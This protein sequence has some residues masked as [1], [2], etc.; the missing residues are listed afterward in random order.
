MLDRINTARMAHGLAPL[1]PNAQLTA[2]ANRHVQ[3]IARNPWITAGDSHIG[4]DG[5]SAGERIRQAG[6]TGE[7]GRECTG[8]GWGDFGDGAQVAWWLDSP[9][10][11]AILLNPTLNEAGVAFQTAIAPAQW[12]RYWVVDFGRGG[13][14]MPSEPPKPPTLPYQSHIPVVVAGGAKTVDLLSY[15]RGDGRAYRVGNSRGSFEVFQTQTEGD[16]FYQIKAWDDLSVVNWEGFSVDD[17]Y[18][19]RD[20]D[21]SPGDG[22]FYRQFD[23]PWVARRMSVGQSFTQSKRVQ[24]YRLADCAPL[25]DYSG[26]VTDTIQLV[27]VHARFTFPARDWPP[28][29]LEDVV[30]LRWTAGEDYWY[31]RGYGLVAWG[32]THQDANSPAWSAISEMRPNVGRLPRLRIG[33]L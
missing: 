33:C 18:I 31:A 28:V 25:G 7:M 13:A 9:P 10:H 11:R 6:Y 20:V 3:D 5:S 14:T 2:A 1:S 16:R 30:Q 22:R 26:G 29:T 8:W 32:R 24:F 4:S 19:R 17:S 12:E 23:A 27:A 21:T 15:L